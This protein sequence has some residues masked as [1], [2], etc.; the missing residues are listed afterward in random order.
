MFKAA[1]RERESLVKLLILRTK[2]AMRKCLFCY[3]LFSN[4][5]LIALGTVNIY[6]LNSSCRFSDAFFVD[7]CRHNLYVCAD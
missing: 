4:A 7:I 3:N 1:L 6:K 2:V 5:K